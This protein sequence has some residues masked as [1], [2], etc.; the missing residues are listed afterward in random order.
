MD[1]IV[2]GSVDNSRFLRACRRQSTDATPIWLMHQAGRYMSEYRQLR[3]KYSI[4][5]AGFLSSAH[6]IEIFK[7]HFQQRRNL[8]SKSLHFNY[9]KY[10]FL[11][12]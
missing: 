5:E 4:L 8:L 3:E 7:I 1:H 11:Y 12:R 10:Y 2:T 9:L 6:T